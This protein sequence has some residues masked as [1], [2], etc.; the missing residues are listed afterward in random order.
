MAT[1][2]FFSGVATF[3]ASQI[4]SG[5]TSITGQTTATWSSAGDYIVRIDGFA[6][7]TSTAIFEDVLVTANNQSTGALT[8]TRAQDS[9]NAQAFAA[10]ATLTPVITLKM[11]TDAFVRLDATNAGFLSFSPGSSYSAPTTLAGS[12]PIKID[13]ILVGTD[14]RYLAATPQITF[15]NT[16]APAFPNLL[17]TGFRHLLIE[18]MARG[19]VAATNV[20]G[21]LR[22]NNDSTTNYGWNRTNATGTAI[23]STDQGASGTSAARGWFLSGST[24]L[25]SAPGIAKIWI[26]N[27]NSTVFKKM[28]RIETSFYNGTTFIA[29][30]AI[31][32]DYTTGYWTAAP[33]AITRID[34]LPSS[35]NFIVGSLFTLYGIP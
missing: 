31:Q 33:T 9:T 32:S 3:C 7:G 6:P 28:I 24:A 8:V 34:I 17:P 15:L 1:K 35:G 23:T 25:A 12:M 11:I 13:D 22:F 5:A 27:Y 21:L 14:S 20:E 10:G 19:D 16:S 30:G 26:P 18:I 4:T 29:A 2:Q